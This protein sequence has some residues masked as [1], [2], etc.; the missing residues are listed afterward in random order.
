ML[1]GPVATEDLAEGQGWIAS[2]LLTAG[3]AV[4]ALAVRD[5]GDRDR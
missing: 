5:F 2:A 3:I 4:I 1:S